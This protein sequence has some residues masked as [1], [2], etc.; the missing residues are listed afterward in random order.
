MHHGF[1][2]PP[3][4]QANAHATRK[5]HGQP[6]FETELRWLVIRPKTNT[7]ETGKGQA[8]GEQ[9]K[10]AGRHQVQPAKIIGRCIEDFLRLPLHRLG[11]GHRCRQK[12]GNQQQR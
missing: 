5:D 3:E 1:G 2:Y 10:A 8:Q 11:V 9:N 12:D 7:A 6:A 4:H